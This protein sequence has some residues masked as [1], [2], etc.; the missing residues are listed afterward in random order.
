MKQK[1]VKRQVR[2]EREQQKSAQIVRKEAEET[3]KARRERIKQRRHCKTSSMTPRRSS[4]PWMLLP[5][6]KES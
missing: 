6:L 3:V 5:K 2:L 1:E 4:R